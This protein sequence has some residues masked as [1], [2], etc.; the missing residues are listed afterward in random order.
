[1]ELYERGILK[2]SRSMAWTLSLGEGLL[3]FIEKIPFRGL[4]PSGR[5]TRIM[6]Q[7]LNADYYAIREGSEVDA[8][9]PGNADRASP[10]P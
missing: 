2:K 8:T 7:R 5:G 9:D 6:G 3:H 10:I 1:M 4:R